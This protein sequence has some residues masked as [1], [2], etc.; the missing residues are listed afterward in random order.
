MK[1]ADIFYSDAFGM[2]SAKRLYEEANRRGLNLSHREIKE[3]YHN[4]EVVQLFAP[5]KKPKYSSTP[6]QGDYTGQNVYFDTMFFPK[7][8]VIN[9]VD[10]Y[11]KYAWGH[12]V[13]LRKRP[14]ETTESVSA[15]KTTAF[16]REVIEDLN[17]KGFTL[18]QVTTDLGSEFFSTFTQTLTDKDIPHIQTD[19]G[20]HIALAP[21]DGYTR[22]LRLAAE[23][24]MAVNPGKDLY[25]QIP[26]LIETY[27]NSPHTNL[28][29]FTPEQAF[30][31]VIER[32]D[33]TTKRE[34]PSLKA[35]DSVRIVARHDKNP[36]N[37]IR[38]NWSREIYTV[39]KVKGQ[40]L[41]LSNGRS[42]RE[43]ELF[44]IPFPE[45]VET[46]PHDEEPEQQEPAPAP[47]KKQEP[48]PL[49]EKS[50][51][52]RRPNQFHQDFV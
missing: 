7:V 37:K 14:D 41:V 48:P 50:T 42:Y 3:W 22:G 12:P 52:Q 1:L 36:Y 44:H 4:Q 26:Q 15:R 47:K 49:R 43:H 30:G 35:G 16:L 29:D 13:R 27:N 17:K 51:R 8:A 32:R 6:I 34:R 21:I 11:S 45:K 40:R 5:L 18:D 31:K 38:P 33:T 20:D 25:K 28:S 10:L 39:E 24:W 23:K 2:R 19:V 9:A 46:A